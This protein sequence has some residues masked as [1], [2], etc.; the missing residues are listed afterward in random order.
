MNHN[1]QLWEINTALN[2]SF[3]TGPGQTMR[4]IL[5]KQP[6]PMRKMVS[7]AFVRDID[8]IFYRTVELTENFEDLQHHINSALRHE[9]EEIASVDFNAA[10][11]HKM[12]LLRELLPVEKFHRVIVTS[13][14]NYQEGRIVVM[15]DLVD[16]GNSVHLIEGLHELYTLPNDLMNS[17][18]TVAGPCRLITEW[19]FDRGIDEDD[20]VKQLLNLTTLRELL[21]AGGV[22]VAEFVPLSTPP[23]G[24]NAYHNDNHML[25]E[26]EPR[27][28]AMFYQPGSAHSINGIYQQLVQLQSTTAR[29]NFSSS[30]QRSRVPSQNGGGFNVSFRSAQA[31]F[32][33]S[34]RGSTFA[35]SFSRGGGGGQGFGA[36]GFGSFNQ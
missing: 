34:V 12:Y 27:E 36:G 18:Q 20:E 1:Q 30:Q 17:Q 23:T 2:N 25:S 13:N 15:V 5:Q 22:F 6:I 14:D 3:S 11:L 26:K 24:L 4:S 32:N 10:Q 8:H 31:G 33:S 35:N 16:F 21:P 19:S 9:D 28:E 29:N 7:I